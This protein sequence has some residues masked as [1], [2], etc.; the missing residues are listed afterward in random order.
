MIVQG[1]EVQLTAAELSPQITL[2][3]GQVVGSGGDMEGG[4]HDLDR[5]IGGRAARS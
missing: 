4:H 2:H 1:S 3:I 5:L